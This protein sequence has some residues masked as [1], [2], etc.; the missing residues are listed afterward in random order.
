MNISK[1]AHYVHAVLMNGRTLF[2]RI[3][4]LMMSSASDG[5]IKMPS[6]I[7]L[8][9]ILSDEFRPPIEFDKENRILTNH[10]ANMAQKRMQNSDQIRFL[11]SYSP[12][13]IRWDK[14]TKTSIVRHE[15]R[16]HDNDHTMPNLKPDTKGE[17]DRAN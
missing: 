3:R 2:K 13:V 8:E 11:F 9:S 16:E 7:D 12:T 14:L 15:E 4:L 5:I 6:M 10:I 1:E 17:A